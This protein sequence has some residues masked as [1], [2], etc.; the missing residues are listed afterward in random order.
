MEYESIDVAGIQYVYWVFTPDHS[1]F[2]RSEEGFMLRRATP[3]ANV[4]DQ[5]TPPRLPN[6]RDLMTIRSEIPDIYR[7][8]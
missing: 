1:L 4:R 8:F 3:D 7:E 5:Q 6:A 2:S